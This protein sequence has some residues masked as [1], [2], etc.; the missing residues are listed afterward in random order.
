MLAQAEDN[1]LNLTQNLGQL[2][3]PIVDLEDGSS[4]ALEQ[5]E[6]AAEAG[7]SVVEDEEKGIR[8]VVEDKS[9]KS[10]VRAL[11]PTQIGKAKVAYPTV[12]RVLIHIFA[13]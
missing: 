8:E 12:K 6:G 9:Q 7:M 11:Q 4:A 13:L 1:A 5:S 3:T 2:W 10:A